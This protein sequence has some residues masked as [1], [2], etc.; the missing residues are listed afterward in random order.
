MFQ[1]F[2]FDNLYMDSTLI[3]KILYADLINA[4]NKPEKHL[5]FV[6]R[7]GRTSGDFTFSK[8]LR[9]G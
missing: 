8:D 3:S 2:V 9:N 5:K 7:K 1:R 6:I 4:D